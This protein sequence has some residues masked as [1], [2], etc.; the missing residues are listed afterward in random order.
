MRLPLFLILASLATTTAAQDR[1]DVHLFK[2]GGIGAQVDQIFGEF[3][4]IMT[5]KLPLLA[6]EVQGDSDISD[7]RNISQL[8]LQP[9]MKRGE[10]E[11]PFIRL[12]SLEARSTY[13]RDTGALAVL[14]GQVQA[15][16]DSG[17]SITSNFFLGQLG[18]R[19]GHQNV[20][21]KLAVRPEAYSTT[22]DSHSVT[23]LTALA[24][25]AIF[26]E[27]M[28]GDPDCSRSAASYAL[29]DQ[30]DQRASSVLDEDAATG[31]RLK[32]LVEETA[33]VVKHECPL[34]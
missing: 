31:R 16:G 23:I 24:L 29:L 22:K 11:D 9:V 4:Y 27:A 8:A 25:S 32:A 20:S 34:G 2:Y 26:P 18:Q 28:N 21:V 12:G 3:L 30:A 17:L 6:S 1:R 7:L 13:W 5:E 33:T 15:Q 10:M 19:V 14:T